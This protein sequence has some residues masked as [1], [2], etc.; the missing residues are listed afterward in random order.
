MPDGRTVECREC[1][2][3]IMFVKNS[4]GKNTPV[5]VEEVE[6]MVARKGEPGHYYAKAYVIHFSTCNSRGRG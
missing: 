4:N 2:A 1:G 5:N 3:P 6:V